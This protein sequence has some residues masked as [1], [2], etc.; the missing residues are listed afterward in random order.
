[1]SFSLW[2]PVPWSITGY[3]KTQLWLWGLKKMVFVE[4]YNTGPPKKRVKKPPKTQ[5]WLFG[6]YTHDN[7]QMAPIKTIFLQMTVNSGQNK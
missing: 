4:N 2:S 5:N 7:I 6:G 3:S 1:M